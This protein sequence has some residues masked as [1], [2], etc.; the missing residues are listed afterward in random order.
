MS[1]GSLPMPCTTVTLAQRPDLRSHFARLHGAAW[2]AYMRHDPAAV[3]YWEE[4]L[5]RLAQ[6]QVLLC[7]DDDQVVAIGN[8]VPVVWSGTPG[9]LPA[10]MR[11]CCKVSP[12]VATGDGR[13]RCAPSP[14]SSTPRAGAAG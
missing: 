5:S 4:L 12:P 2:P 9:G 11:P 1:E 8:S 7:G 6:Y 10:G 3:V 14:P 13:R